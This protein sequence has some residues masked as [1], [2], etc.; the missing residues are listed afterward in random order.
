MLAPTQSNVGDRV[1]AWAISCCSLDAVVRAKG[2]SNQT[3]IAAPEKVDETKNMG[4]RKQTKQI[5]GRER[6]DEKNIRGRTSR[7]LPD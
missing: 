1:G 3:R 5:L 7:R 4:H 6:A 2:E